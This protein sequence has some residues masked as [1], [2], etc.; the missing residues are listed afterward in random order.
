VRLA[1]PPAGAEDEIGRA[2]RADLLVAEQGVFD[3]LRVG[4]QRDR[5]PE[6]VLEG[7]TGPLADVV[8]AASPSSATRPRTQV[9]K[10]S[11]SQISTRFSEASGSIV[12]ISRRTPGAQPAKASWSGRLPSARS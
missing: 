5:Q 11:T 12:S 10:G 8:W 1:A 6:G 2:C 9:W 3:A 7:R 4:R